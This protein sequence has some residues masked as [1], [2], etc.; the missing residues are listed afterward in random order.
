MLLLYIHT[1]ERVYNTAAAALYNTTRTNMLPGRRKD[2]WQPA[3]AWATRQHEREQTRP[4]LQY[5]GC[6]RSLICCT[7]IHSCTYIECI[8]PSHRSIRDSTQLDGDLRAHCRVAHL[9][10]NQPGA[11]ALHAAHL[12]CCE[13]GPRTL[14]DA[15]A[16]LPAGPAVVAVADHTQASRYLAPSHTPEVKDH[17]TTYQSKLRG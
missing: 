2:P 4:R 5:P 11:F 15:T 1:V 9:A 3:R 16:C 8:P 10:K 7:T 12:G 17:C 6:Q 14:L 13:V